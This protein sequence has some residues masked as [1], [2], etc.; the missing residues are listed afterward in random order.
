MIFST[1]PLLVGVFGFSYLILAWQVSSSFPP[2]YKKGNIEEDMKLVLPLMFGVLALLATSVIFHNLFILFGLLSAFTGIRVRRRVLERTNGPLPWLLSP[3]T[4]GSFNRWPMLL[5]DV[6][7]I[8]FSALM[9][10]LMFAW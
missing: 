5:F 9:V 2:F 7:T 8:G 10:L 3:L 1:I 4:I 6:W